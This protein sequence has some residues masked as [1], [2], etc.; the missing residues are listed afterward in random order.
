[1]SANDPLRTFAISGLAGHPNSLRRL[2]GSAL[3]G[4]VHEIWA[5]PNLDNPDCG[6]LFSCCLAGPGGDE[7][8][9]LN[10]PA[11]R[12]VGTFE[13]GSHF[14]AM[15]TFNQRVYGQSYSTDQKRDHEPYPAEWLSEQQTVNDR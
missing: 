14:E 12:L 7:A 5:E 2:R 10:S 4:L 9:A 13:A 6:E 15:T 1:M 11:A 3:V 8:R